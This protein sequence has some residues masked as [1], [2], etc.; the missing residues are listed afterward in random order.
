MAK[1]K[2]P[3]VVTSIGELRTILSDGELHDFYMQLNFGAISRKQISRA[4]KNGRKFWIFNAIDGSDELLTEKQLNN[5]DFCNIG[6]AIKQL[7][8]WCE[9]TK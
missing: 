8:F 6:L 7:A 5:A 4:G 2:K 9:D 1:P 3:F